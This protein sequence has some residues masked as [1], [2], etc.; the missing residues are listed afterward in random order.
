MAANQR[1]QMSTTSDV[2]LNSGDLTAFSLNAANLKVAK[3]WAQGALN[4]TSSSPGR[5]LSAGVI[6]HGGSLHVIDG[7]DDFTFGL[8]ACAAQLW[9]PIGK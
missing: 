6:N 4:T 5:Q 8:S 7:N 9:V 2:Q 3:L 1:R